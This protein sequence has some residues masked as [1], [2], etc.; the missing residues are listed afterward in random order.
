MP[1]SHSPVKYMIRGVSI[2]HAGCHQVRV[3]VSQPVLLVIGKPV[4][5]SPGFFKPLLFAVDYL[6]NWDIF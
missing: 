5:N 2:F 4:V 3:N 1:D 6:Q